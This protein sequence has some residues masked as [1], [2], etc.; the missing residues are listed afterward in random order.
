MHSIVQIM[1]N[2]LQILEPKNQRDTTM[3]I[4]DVQDIKK[5]KHLEN[6]S[7]ICPPEN[8]TAFALK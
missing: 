2:R 1:N 5:K 3:L 7:L 4:E 6:H 8:L